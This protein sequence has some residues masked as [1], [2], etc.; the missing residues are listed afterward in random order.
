MRAQY[1]FVGYAV[2]PAILIRRLGHII[3]KRYKGRVPTIL[4][5]AKQLAKGEEYVDA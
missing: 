2:I 4:F 5:V 3:V 1:H